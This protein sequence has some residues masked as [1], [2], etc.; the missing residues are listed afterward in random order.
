MHFIIIII[1]EQI[2]EGNG[3]L[4]RLLGFAPNIQSYLSKSEN[5]NISPSFAFNQ[6]ND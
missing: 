1:F 2:R 6:P 3:E 5:K 4:N